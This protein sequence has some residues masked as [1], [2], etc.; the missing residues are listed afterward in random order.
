MGRYYKFDGFGKMI[1]I[2]K[3]TYEGNWKQGQYHGKG[4]YQWIKYDRYFQGD[5]Y[6]GKRHGRGIQIIGDKLII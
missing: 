1:Y 3:G 6:N 4:K 2:D 5:Y